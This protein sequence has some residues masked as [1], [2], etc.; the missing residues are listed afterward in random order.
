MFGFFIQDASHKCKGRWAK[1]Q[2]EGKKGRYQGR[3][4]ASEGECE[5]AWSSLEGVELVDGVFNSVNF[6]KLSLAKR[7]L[8]QSTGACSQNYFSHAVECYA[9]NQKFRTRWSVILKIISE[10][11]QHKLYIRCKKYCSIA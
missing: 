10:E 6:L 8:P 4:E 11:L 5:C 7:T 3:G 9:K 1:K 2:L